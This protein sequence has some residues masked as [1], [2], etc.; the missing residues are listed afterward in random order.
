MANS[1]RKLAHELSISFLLIAAPIF[2]LAL[3]I[4]YIQSRQLIHQKV[5]ASTHSTLNSTRQR[6]ENYMS[7][8]ETAA[9]ANAW[10]MEEHFRQDSLKSVSNRIVRLNPS[11]VSSSLFVVPDLWQGRTYSLFSVR[12]DDSVTTY[13]EPEY[14]Y[15]DMECYTRPV[16]TG[17]TC[18]LDPF[19]DNTENKVD[20]QAAVATYCRP[21]R[22]PDGR[23][24]GVL[25]TDLSF[26]SM[27]SIL[28]DVEQPYSH[29]YY[30]LLG[31]DGRFLIH[32]DT[33]RLFHKTIFTD[34]DPDKDKDIITL[35]YEM[36]AGKQG[37]MHIRHNG[38]LYHVCY[39]PVEGTKWSMALVCP[40][41]D[42]MQSYYHL[43]YII[44]ALLIAGLL[45]SVVLCNHVVKR[46][47][48]PIDKLI[49]TTQQIADGQYYHTIPTTSEKGIIALLQ[50][51]F[52]KMQQSL[53]DHMSHLQQQGEALRQHNETLLGDKQ[54]V[55]DTVSNKNHFIHHLTQQIRMPLSTITGF[56]DVLAESSADKGTTNE[57]ELHSIQ[58]MMKSN[59]VSMNRMV[60]LLYDATETDATGTLHCARADEVSCNT[61]A[62]ECIDYML[63]HLPYANI[64]FESEL[65][66]SLCILT[67]RVYLWYS[68][69][70]LLRNA[71]NG[72]DGQH[73][74]LRITQT[75]DTVRFTV[76]DTGPGLPADLDLTFTPFTT[77][78]VKGMGL[79]LINRH[80]VNLGGTMTI[81]RDYH[82]GC[83]VTVELPK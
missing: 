14:G 30:M 16:T 18:W 49:K 79:R 2:V 13:E 52:A 23:I 40:D 31:S 1:R 55:E 8:V 26:S 12:E 51:S 66:D 64:Q 50:N 34:A 28:N 19:I 20:P 72:S 67:N 25:T 75:A 59:T 4:L 46:A 68:V 62:H 5:M 11:V 58:D 77:E 21:L 3:G 82:D 6:I 17:R 70:E 36:T 9:N 81:D 76:Q 80:T 83:R 54:Q 60:L 15:L 39:Q 61:F 63:S 32:P 38:E 53:D 56:A 71:I 78:A 24:V 57:Q 37:T 35:G 42:A 69:C 45:A 33:T 41:G 44:L 7:T 65:P 43:G 74:V 73:I 22:Q 47:I 27:A 29:S 48:S 10:M